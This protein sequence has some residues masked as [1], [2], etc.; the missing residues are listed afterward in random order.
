MMMGIPNIS[1]ILTLKMIQNPRSEVSVV[2]S[3]SKRSVKR[4]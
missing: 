1:N 3:R 2:V 4:S